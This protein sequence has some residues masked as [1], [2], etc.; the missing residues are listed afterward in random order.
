MR[1]QLAK[2]CPGKLH[3]GI[4]FNNDN[5]AAH[6]ARITKEVLREFQWE[7]LSH[8]PYSPDLPPSD[9]FLLPK[10]KEKLKGVHFNSTN[11]AKHA[12]KI[13]LTKLSADFFKNCLKGWKHHLEK[14]IDNGE[15]YDEK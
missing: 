4:L 7:L 1:A 5:A 6:S 15:A 9:F 11:E 14:C 10:L 12:P 2:K 3:R 8:P 13:W